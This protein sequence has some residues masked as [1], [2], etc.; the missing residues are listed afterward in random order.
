[1]SFARTHGQRGADVDT[2]R[3]TSG[4][5]YEGEAKVKRGGSNNGFCGCFAGSGD[6]EPK[7]DRY[8]LIKGAACF[9][10][11]DEEAPSPKYAIMLAH[12]KTEVDDSRVVLESALGDVDYCFVFKNAEEA[13]K[14][15]S[16]VAEQAAIGEAEEVKKR[17]GHDHLLKKRSSVKYAQSIAAK[18]AKDQPDQPI[19]AADVMAAV[20]VDPLTNI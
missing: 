9:V 7:K 17:L 6:G 2:L 1:M 3:G 15:A 16:A 8:I 5:N 18:K 19:T 10:F 12:M 20:P 13:Q 11:F 4:A 14:F